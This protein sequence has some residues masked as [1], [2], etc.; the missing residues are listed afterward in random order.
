MSFKNV[1]RAREPQR[2]LV[3]NAWATNGTVDN[4]APQFHE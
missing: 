3:F 1:D 2:R 4:T